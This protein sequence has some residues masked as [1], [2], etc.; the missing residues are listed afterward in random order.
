MSAE[1]V[2]RLTGLPALDRALARA[3]EELAASARLRL[4]V[5]VALAL[6]LAYWLL[7]RSADLAAAG[8]AHAAAVER[9]ERAEALLATQDWRQRLAAA[10]AADA[11]LA[12]RFWRA[13]T[14]A[15]AQA[16]LR[17]ALADIAAGAGI[18]EPRLQSGVGQPASDASGLW[19][20]QVRLAGGYESGGELRLLYA[21][22][23]QEKQIVVDRL[24][25]TPGRNARLLLLASAYFVGLAERS[26][27]VSGAAPKAGSGVD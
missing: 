6:L 25:I 4:G 20:A 12:D 13:E 8:A 14:P 19:R 24:D 18:D 3:A 7:V 2:R 15:Q 5:Y 10:G 16:Q 9:L 17:K 11:A 21:L 1:P 23:T 27:D 22:A 26:D